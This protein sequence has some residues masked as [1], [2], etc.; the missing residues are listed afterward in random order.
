MY[1]TM[2]SPITRWV[3]GKMHLVD[4]LSRDLPSFNTYIEPCAGSACLCFHIR[5]SKFILNDTNTH[6]TNV[7]SSIRADPEEV[8]SNLRTITHHYNISNA[9]ER[10]RLYYDIRDEFNVNNE[11][12]KAEKA[13]YFVFLNKTCFNGL[14]RYN[15]KKHFNVS[16]NKKVKLDIPSFKEWIDMHSIM[17]NGDIYNL[18]YEDIVYKAIQGDFIYFDPPHTFNIIQHKR[19]HFLFKKC[20]SLGVYAMM[21]FVDDPVLNDMYSCYELERVHT[22]HG[23]GKT[24]DAIMIVR[25]WLKKES[26]SDVKSY[27]IS[28]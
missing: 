21:T 15:K 4:I 19:M 26:F 24:K 12:S 9:E 28:F 23:M 27:I 16:H 25:S 3:G 20:D 14:C 1:V 10:N 6:L 2:R 7:F 22:Q 11:L 13:A 17:E 8:Y 5:P 18:N